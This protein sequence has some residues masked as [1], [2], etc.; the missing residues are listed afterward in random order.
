MRTE[1]IIRLETPADIDAIQTVNIDAFANH[2]ISHQTEHLIVNALRKANVLMLSLVAELDGKV[3][4]HIAFSP[5]PIN[6]GDLSWFTLGPIAVLP[7]YQKNGIGSQLINAGLDAMKSLGAK[8]CSLVGDPN[9]YQRFGFR[10]SDS[11][12]IPGVPAEYFM[13]LPFADHIP[14]GEVAIHPAFF[15]TAKGSESSSI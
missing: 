6:G 10:H 5:T 15:V 4:G 9:Y 12:S 7:A 2:P 1:T 13:C 14:R 3:V 11:L 8:G